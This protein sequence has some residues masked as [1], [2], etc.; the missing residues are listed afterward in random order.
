MGDWDISVIKIAGN[1]CFYGSLFCNSFIVTTFAANLMNRRN[2]TDLQEKIVRLMAFYL[3][4]SFL[5]IETGS[6]NTDGSMLC[7]SLANADLFFT[8]RRNKR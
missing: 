6:E 7:L 3:V 2:G 8:D 1:L 5:S 4:T